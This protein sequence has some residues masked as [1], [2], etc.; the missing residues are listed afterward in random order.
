VRFRAHHDERFVLDSKLLTADVRETPDGY[1]GIWVELD[2][3][4]E[5]WNRYGDLK[6]FR[7]R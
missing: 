6:G 3:D 7:F 2:V 4:E 5:Q 1:L